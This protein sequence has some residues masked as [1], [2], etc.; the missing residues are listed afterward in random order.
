MNTPRLEGVRL[1]APA[2]VKHQR[3]LDWV[4]RMAALSEADK[5]FGP[6]TR[7]IGVSW[8]QD[9]AKFSVNRVDQRKV[10][11]LWVIS[12]LANPRPTLE[13]YKYAMPGEENQ[14]QEEI[15]VVNIAAKKAVP[16]KVEAF[17]DQQIGLE[18]AP[19]TNLE[20]EKA[21]G[22]GGRGGGAGGGGGLPSKWLAMVGQ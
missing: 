2:Y 6:R 18:S 3:L 20:R 13:T 10:N 22:G 11:D 7:S 1:N 17:K 19:V 21:G 16:V 14:P 9:N 4:A 15:M 5:K 12:A 8:A